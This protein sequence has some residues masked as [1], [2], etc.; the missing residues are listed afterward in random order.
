M[1]RLAWE[2]RSLILRITLLV[3][4]IVVTGVSI[5]VALDSGRMGRGME[6][7]YWRTNYALNRFQGYLSS[8]QIV[9]HRLPGPT[10]REAVKAIRE[11]GEEYNQDLGVEITKPGLDGWGREL[12]YE[13]RGS[14]QAIVRSVGANGIDENGAGDDIQREIPIAP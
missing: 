7:R 12:I 2:G 3:G 6:D 9:H 11:D 4:V 14:E 10:I 13:R 8:Y 5:K 1:I